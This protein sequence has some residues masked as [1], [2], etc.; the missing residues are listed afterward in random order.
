MP[1]RKTF[2][3]AGLA[4][5]AVLALASLAGGVAS[6]DVAVIDG[7]IQSF[8]GTNIAFTLFKPDGA[9]PESKVPVIL[10]THGWGGSRVTDPANG[11][12]ARLL[13]D[14]YAVL[15][16]DQRGF[17]ISGGEANVD[18]QEFEVRDVQALMTFVADQEGIL[19]DDSESFETIQVEV[20]C[21]EDT[22]EEEQPCFEEEVIRH[23]PVDPR[24]GM[25]GGSYAGGIQLMT[26]AADPRVDAIVPQIA[27]NDLPQSLKPN[28]VLKLG[29]DLLLYGSGAASAATG[30]L[31]DGET[32]IYSPYIHQSVVEGVALNDWS[33]AT[34]DW[35]DAKSPAR[36]INGATL[37]D[38]TAVPGI[39]AP[40]LIIQG[41]SDTLFPVNEGI[42][43]Y[44]QILANGVDAKMI[45][46]CG[47]HTL[48]PLG[49]S[50]AAGEGQGAHINARIDAWFA[51]YLKGQ[52]ADT[53][54]AIEYQVQD[55]R[56][57]SL[58]ELPDA[59][60]AAS[61]ASRV[62]HQVA[63]TS[64][65]VTA[66]TSGGCRDK[67]GAGELGSTL[68]VRE[69]AAYAQVCP[70]ASSSWIKVGTYTGPPPDRCGEPGRPACDPTFE[71][72]KP[73]DQIVGSTRVKLDVITLLP[74]PEAYLFLKLVS[75]HRESNTATVIDDQVMALRVPWPS[76][77][78]PT[79]IEVD[80][81]AVAWE[82]QEGHE[83]YIEVSPNS[84]DHASS[85]YP[86]STSFTLQASVP[87]IQ[88]SA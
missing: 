57:F 20:E 66:G 62:T 51:R 25:L 1:R 34:S 10:M 36:Y 17:G 53:G 71:F 29:W 74:T 87:V 50:C 75:Y 4:L 41:T 42:A 23:P 47:G 67:D 5:T 73:G 18:S 16:W 2:R 40:A 38:G 43:N 13:G 6:A 77:S 58:D 68:W 60:I 85:R 80:M 11:T 24:M 65:Q 9:G 48:T 55:G 54:P 35:F 70:Y 64:G 31:N 46:F 7:K 86:N 14:G 84:N 22:P 37:P 81:T 19:T 21:P 15:T 63:P 3:A 82:V 83:I 30:G 61:A 12:V 26:A 45:W 88:A 32:G 28:G 76:T 27:W 52:D 59:N 69:A 78:Q 8:D 49:T 79:T 33:T 44:E 72:L 39:S 56:W